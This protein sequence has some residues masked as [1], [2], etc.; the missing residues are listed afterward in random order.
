MKEITIR[1]LDSNGDLIKEDT[2]EVKEGNVIIHKVPSNTPISRA[3][4]MHDGIKHVLQSEG[5]RVLT[6][7]NNSSIQIMSIK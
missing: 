5:E 1:T 7:S 2:I 4:L 3:K 6:I